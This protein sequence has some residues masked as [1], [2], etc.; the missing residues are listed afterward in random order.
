MPVLPSK[1]DSRLEC[2]W[3]DDS[4]SLGWFKLPFVDVL[5][6]ALEL[7]LAR[8]AVVAAVLTPEHGAWK[9]LFVRIDA[10]FGFVVPFKVPKALGDDWT[11]LLQTCILSRLAIVAFLMIIKSPTKITPLR[12]CGTAGETA[13][14]SFTLNPRRVVITYANLKA[15]DTSTF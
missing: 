5:V 7:V 3:L 10:V 12:N 4:T 8:K 2:S 15:A 13:L 1:L 14:P 6:M 11:V 9:L